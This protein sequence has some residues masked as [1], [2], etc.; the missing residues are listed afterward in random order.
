MIDRDLAH[1]SDT[2]TFSV[3]PG[4]HEA[5]HFSS[6]SQNFLSVLCVPASNNRY[7]SAYALRRQHALAFAY[8]LDHTVIRAAETDTDLPDE[9]FG[10]G[11]ARVDFF[12]KVY[13]NRVI[14]VGFAHSDDPPTAT[15]PIDLR[16]AVRLV[17]WLRD[18]FARSSLE[19]A[20]KCGRHRALCDAI[21]WA[22][23]VA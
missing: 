16:T 11:H 22:E 5:I 9:C 6:P 1:H 12:L 8:N 23:G 15:V 13:E 10:I 19:L 17:Y 3:E 14:E 21:G 7:P 4:G 2:P 20:A 18:R